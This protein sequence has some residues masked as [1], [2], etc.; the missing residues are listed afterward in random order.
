MTDRDRHNDA[1][2]L[3]N[4]EST[5]LGT[6]TNIFLVVQSVLVAGLANIIISGVTAVPYV[7]AG[8][9]SGMSILG[10][11]YCLMQYIAGRQGAL[12]A[13][14]WQR[15]MRYV[16]EEKEPG[17]PWQWFYKQWHQRKLAEWENPTQIGEPNKARLIRRLLRKLAYPFIWKT[18]ETQLLYKLPWPSTW[19]F[20]PTIFSSVWFI[21]ALY[22]GVRL[23]YATDPIRLSL[24]ALW[25]TYLE[26]V[27]IAIIVVVALA[28]IIASAVFIR[29]IIK[30]LKWW[31][32]TDLET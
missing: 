8:A 28:V 24:D 1:I 18:R 22:I 3:R 13:F 25:N 10:S 12:A 27:L 30:V 21:A 6:R 7:F 32:C 17:E 31:Y 26:F 2:Q 16:E 11:I 5:T 14:R 9:V 20:T 29:M 19:L 15:Y 23:C 4:Q